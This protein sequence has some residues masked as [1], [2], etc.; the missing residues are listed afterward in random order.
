MTS[1]QTTIDRLSQTHPVLQCNLTVKGLIS[2]AGRNHQKHP[3]VT[4]QD[5]QTDSMSPALQVWQFHTSPKLRLSNDQINPITH[6]KN[7]LQFNHKTL[8]TILYKSTKSTMISCHNLQRWSCASALQTSCQNHRH[9][10]CLLVPLNHVTRS[11]QSQ[12][13]NLQLGQRTPA[14]VCNDVRDWPINPTDVAP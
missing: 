7:T 4:I 11:D 5:R 10:V 9:F 1:A 13:S 3:A 8:N 12:A 14:C 6:V 2:N